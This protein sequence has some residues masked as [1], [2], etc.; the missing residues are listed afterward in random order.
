MKK[1]GFIVSISLIIFFA[2]SPKNIELETRVQD[3]ATGKWGYAD[4]K[5][6]IIISGKYDLAENFQNDLGLAKVYVGTLRHGNQDET[7]QGEGKWG[8][9]D[10]TGKEIV[11]CKYDKIR[12]F[13]DG[14][15]EVHIGRVYNGAS[16]DGKF[17]FIDKTG[18]EVIPCK[19]DNVR[20]FSEGLVAVNIGGKFEFIRENN[21]YSFSGGKWG[22]VDR[23]GKE[24][25]PFE[26]DEADK[27]S[28]SKAW[29]SISENGIRKIGYIDKTG[30]FITPPVEHSFTNY[31]GKTA[32]EGGQT[33]VITLTLETK[34]N[35]KN[36]KGYNISIGRDNMTSY[37]EQVR[38]SIK[39][40]SDD[41]FS[42]ERL[43]GTVKANQINCIFTRNG[44]QKYIF[45]A[46]PKK[47]E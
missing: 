34:G 44:G 24:V 14:L 36:I 40:E 39:V 30:K 10:K 16:V 15:A 4:K 8:L 32:A 41:V 5:G 37:E 42:S 25:I 27:F 26:Y 3:K 43:S 35:E 11:P 23:T 38:S 6:R 46:Y 19:Y 2:C 31:T 28:E 20:S 33:L 45:S 17:G 22:Y 18:V 1:G 7:N 21:R 13:N 47:S 12:Y 29:V 9:I